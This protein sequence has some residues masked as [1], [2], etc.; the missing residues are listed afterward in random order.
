MSMVDLFASSPE[1]WVSLLWRIAVRRYKL[2]A[3]QQCSCL[4]CAQAESG[5]GTNGAYDKVIV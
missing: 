1:P 5:F 4:P 3:L 2:I